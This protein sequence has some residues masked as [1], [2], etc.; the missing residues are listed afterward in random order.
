MNDRQL[1]YAVKVRD[2]L[3]F[4][5]AAERLLLSQSSISEQV[6]MLEAELGFALF[7]RAGRG[8]EVTQAGRIFLHQA[9]QILANLGGLHELGRQLS[10][11]PARRFSVGVS[12][13][14]IQ[15]IIPMIADALRATL[16]DIRLSI[17]TG[18]TPQV[19]R[20]VMQQV[21]DVGITIQISAP[22]ANA[23]LM[24][25]P[26]A[27]LDI[28]LFVPPTHRLAA[29]SRPI[30][31]AELAG[32][33]LIMSEPTL[34]YGALVQS[35][36]ADQGVRPNIVS[37]ADQT[38]TLKMMIR[39]GVGVGILPAIT[40]CDE[41]T[42][43]HLQQLALRP[44]RTVSLCL[45]RSAKPLDSHVESCISLVRMALTKERWA[46]RFKPPSRRNRRGTAV[47]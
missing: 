43:G 21:L 14:I 4:S 37:I 10:H 23:A 44:G 18:M 7:R 27:A 16:P 39:A 19:Q 36:F 38:N 24:S 32:E 5:R 45:V 11:G 3:S 30:T 6:N 34:G 35:M 25:E 40:A 46:L 26:I 15:V 2:E 22:A 1:R 42:A 13:A 33:P 31:F 47:A 41:V 28:A 9:E 12:P 17:A 20:L 8:V 29:V